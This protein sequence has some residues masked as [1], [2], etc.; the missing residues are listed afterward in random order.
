MSLADIANKYYES[1]KEII[2]ISHSDFAVDP[3]EPYDDASERVILF[4]ESIEEK[5]KNRLKY[6][7]HT[8]ISDQRICNEIMI[9]CLDHFGKDIDI[10]II[11]NEIVEFF[12]FVNRDFFSVLCKPFKQQLYK[13]LKMNI[14]T[15]MFEKKIREEQIRKS[16]CVQPTF[17]DII[18]KSI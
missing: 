12:G 4:L 9:E 14:N 5:Y 15:E 16:G 11:Y 7:K 2:K 8:T 1:E 13:R 18:R 6:T 10:M 3:E 17:S